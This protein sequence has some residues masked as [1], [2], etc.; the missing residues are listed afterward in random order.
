MRLLG[1]DEDCYSRKYEISP[2]LNSCK[3]GN[4]KRFVL[5]VSLVSL[6]SSLVC[7]RI[8][9]FSRLKKPRISAQPFGF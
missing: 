3:S 4:V 8:A 2:F 6:L 9:A 1:G 5:T 7:S